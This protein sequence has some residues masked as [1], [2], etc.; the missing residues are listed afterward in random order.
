LVNN[1]PPYLI[2]DPSFKGGQ[3]ILIPDADAHSIFKLL[4]EDFQKGDLYRT[5]MKNEPFL[6]VRRIS[7]HDFD[8]GAQLELLVTQV[9][10]DVS[11]HIVHYDYNREPMH[12]S[13]QYLKIVKRVFTSLHREI[14]SE[15]MEQ[16]N[17]KKLLEVE[18]KLT[19]GLL[20]VLL[21]SILI[22]DFALLVKESI[23]GLLGSIIPIG[24]ILYYLFKLKGKS[25]KFTQVSDG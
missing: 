25:S 15:V 21:S 22:V 20:I 24:L 6:W 16:L 2:A 1:Q 18:D 14:P 11:L 3:T 7:Y 12:Y 19:F 17:F 13:D 23:I 9:N 4:E 8:M 10:E 5:L